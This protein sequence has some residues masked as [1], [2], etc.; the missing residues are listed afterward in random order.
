MEFGAV[1]KRKSN[2]SMGRRGAEHSPSPGLLCHERV[3]LWA[4]RKET[5]HKFGFLLTSK[6]FQRDVS[7]TFAVVL[8]CGLRLAV[9]WGLSRA[10]FAP[11]CSET[12][13]GWPKVPFL[14]FTFRVPLKTTKGHHWVEFVF[15]CYFVPQRADFW[16]NQDFLGQP[17]RAGGQQ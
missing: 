3:E 7:P 15:F 2:G 11:R 16:G 1:F 5:E 9:F 17:E 8:P 6:H 14:P 4:S 12:V 10:I 13:A